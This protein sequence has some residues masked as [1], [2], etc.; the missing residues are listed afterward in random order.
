[1]YVFGCY[2]KVVWKYLEENDIVLVIEDGDMEFFFFVKLD[3][4]GVNYY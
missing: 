3:F 2:L 4:M 1:M